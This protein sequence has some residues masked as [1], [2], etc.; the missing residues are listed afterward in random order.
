MGV[1]RLSS[2]Q[3]AARALR[4]LGLSDAGV[5][6]FSAEALAAS[7]RR[8]AAFLCPATRGAIVRSVVEVLDGLP[9]YSDDTKGQLELLLESLV[10]YGDLL[11]LS[12]NALESG[13]FRLFL[14]APSFVRRASGSRLLIG[15]RPDGAPLV[16]DDLAALIDYEGHAR[17]VGPTSGLDDLLATSGLTER[18]AAQWLQAPRQ[19]TAR[20][21]LDQY[22]RRLQA[23][24]PSGDVDGVGLLDPETRVTYYRGRW[25][26]PKPRD[27]GA[28]VGRRPQA[29][30]AD[31]WCFVRV[32]AGA[33][34]HLVDL[35]ALGLLVPAADEAWRVQAAIDAEAGHPQVVRVRTGTNRDTQVLDLFAPLP[36]WAQRRL[37]VVGTPIGR[38]GGALFSYSVPASEV[39]EELQFLGDMLWMSI[40]HQ[41]ER[42]EP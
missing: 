40:D 22:E 16:G 19:T 28:F 8:A 14:G 42:T 20:E 25:R 10:G 36:S 5:D 15:I 32:T 4:S 1:T 6:L 17:L 35:P 33:V 11:E 9:G 37:D 13:A 41:S 26:P 12:S 27:A 30:G 38:G 39:A 34:T 21:L 2:S 29:Y 7:L 23:A 31:L 3:V 24:G 18:T